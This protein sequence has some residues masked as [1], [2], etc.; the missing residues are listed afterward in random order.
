MSYKMQLSNNRACLMDIVEISDIPDISILIDKDQKEI[1]ALKYNKECFENILSVIYSTYKNSIQLDRNTNICLSLVFKSNEVQNQ[2]YSSKVSI[3]LV[4]R[5]IGNDN[6]TLNNKFYSLFSSLK[7]ILKNGKYGINDSFNKEDVV[8]DISSISS[9]SVVALYKEPKT[10][11]FQLS[12]EPVC[13]SCN[14]IPIQDINSYRIIKMLND[15]NASIVVLDVIPTSYLDS[16]RQKIE[17]FTTILDNTRRG[18]GMFGVSNPL[19]EDVFNLYSRMIS[20]ATKP[21]YQFNIYCASKNNNGIL[22]DNLTSSISNELISTSVILNNANTITLPWY[23]NNFVTKNIKGMLPTN[24]K[25]MYRLSLTT[26]L[27]ETKEFFRIP[28]GNGSLTAG[29]NIARYDKSLSEFPEASVEKSDIVVGKL[30]KDPTKSIG[31]SY[32]SLTKNMLISGTPGSG[33]TTFAVNLLYDLWNKEKIPFFVI[34]PVKTEY[35][36]MID[37]IDNLQVFTPGKDNVSP[38][39]INPFIPPKYVNIGTYKSIL[40]KAFSTAIPLPE[41]SPINYLLD[42]TISEC[43]KAFGWYDDSTIDDEGV[44]IFTI[45]DFLKKFFYIFNKQGYRGEANNI[46]IAGMLRLRALL[47]KVGNNYNTISIDEL[48][49]KPTIV[50][51]DAIKNIED[52]NLITTLLLLSID[53]YLDEI[54][55]FEKLKNGKKLRNVLLLDEAHVLFET[56]HESSSDSAK[57]ILRNM[58]A[59]KRAS[60]MGIVISDQSPG[61]LSKEVVAFTNIKLTFNLVEKEDKEILQNSTAMENIPTSRFNSLKVGE[62]IYYINSISKPE[63]VITEDFRKK[64]NLNDNISDD[65]LKLKHRYWNNKKYMTRPYKPCQKMDIC[66]TGC[67][68]HMRARAEKYALDYIEKHLDEIKKEKLD[69]KDIQKGF[70]ATLAKEHSD[71]RFMKCANI[72]FVHIFEYKENYIF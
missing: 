53:S 44:R 26:N 72:H 69:F 7:S 40:K 61:R 27:E 10:H 13:I 64:M 54:S 49:S 5:M 28:Y 47:R 42:E 57:N 39:I 29:V 12:K 22:A 36:E 37:L 63:E 30:K 2:I 25:D 15:S 1:D 45:D 56:D 24:L 70:L 20:S 46:G 59:E 33:K 8:N 11:N 66:K 71:L 58:L 6:L 32:N 21:L 52:K 60:G 55:K 35:R 68:Y 43:Y 65:E 4:L 67:D 19:V 9:H 18:V 16:E 41:E 38:L 14:Q 3:Y 17:Q 51:L 62:A 34:E 48:L 23:I 31:F 50:E